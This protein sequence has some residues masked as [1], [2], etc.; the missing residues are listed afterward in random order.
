MSHYLSNTPGSF[1]AKRWAHGWGS[2]RFGGQ[3]ALAL[4]AVVSEH[5]GAPA[6]FVWRNIDHENANDFRIDWRTLFHPQSVRVLFI[7][8]PD[9]S[10]QCHSLQLPID[11]VDSYIRKR[12]PDW[13]VRPE[14][15]PTP[16]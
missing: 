12:L 5:I 2:D 1:S 13:N 15:G 4:E 3:G 10:R 16:K 7:V 8:W 6:H 9:D 11:L 14:K